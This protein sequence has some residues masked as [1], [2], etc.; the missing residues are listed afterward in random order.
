MVESM[1]NVGVIILGIVIGN[2]LFYGIMA[3]AGGD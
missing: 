3:V 2:I 1:I